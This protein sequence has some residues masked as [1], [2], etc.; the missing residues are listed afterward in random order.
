MLGLV[1]ERASDSE[2]IAMH[3]AASH[4]FVRVRLRSVWLFGDVDSRHQSVVFVD[5]VGP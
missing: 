2:R 1:M 5:N 3:A 4:T